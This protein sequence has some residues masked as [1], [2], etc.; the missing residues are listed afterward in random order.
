MQLTIALSVPVAHAGAREAGAHFFSDHAADHVL[1]VLAEIGERRYRV[2]RHP[3][4]P[5]GNLE[6]ASRAAR[7]REQASKDKTERYM[8]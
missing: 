8:S 4:C 6:R 5:L 2:L 3:V 1:E 7:A